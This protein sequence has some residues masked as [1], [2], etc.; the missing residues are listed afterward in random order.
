MIIRDKIVRYVTTNGPTSVRDLSKA[1]H[2]KLTS[3]GPELYTL[4]KAGTLS[5]L[6]SRRQRMYGIKAGTKAAPKRNGK[7]PTVETPPLVNDQTIRD[8]LSLRLKYHEGE[9]AR[10]KTMLE[11]LA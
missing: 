4:V 3:V 9:V 6:G 2:A 11:T 10:T 8:I 1:I 7:P 5:A